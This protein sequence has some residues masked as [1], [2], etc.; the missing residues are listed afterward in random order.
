M[1]KG[2]TLQQLRNIQYKKYKSQSIIPKI[3]IKPQSPVIMKNPKDIIPLI[4]VKIRASNCPT[5]PR[6]PMQQKTQ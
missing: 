6:V 5:H 2:P 1:L 4:K 3:I